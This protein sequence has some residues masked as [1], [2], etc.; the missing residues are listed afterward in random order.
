MQRCKRIILRIGMKILLLILSLYLSGAQAAVYA[1]HACPDFSIILCETELP[2]E[3]CK[4]GEKEG[5]HKV[6]SDKEGEWFNHSSFT[7]QVALHLKYCQQ[8][9]TAT[10]CKHSKSLPTPPPDTRI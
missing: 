3:E 8:I 1:M 2:D 5:Y 4:D 9:Q 10:V 7:F 6:K